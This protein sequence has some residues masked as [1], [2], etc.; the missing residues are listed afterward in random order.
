MIEAG[1]HDRGGCRARQPTGRIP[2]AV[3]GARQ[4][5]SRRPGAGRDQTRGWGRTRSGRLDASSDVDECGSRDLAPP[6][7]PALTA[8]DSMPSLKGVKVAIL[9]DDGFEQVELTG[10]R[11]AL[12]V[13]MAECQVVSPKPDQVRAW[14]FTDWGDKFPV[15]VPL[16][17]ANPN[18]FDALLLPGGV[19]NPDSLRMQPPAV[20]FVKAWTVIEAGAA[21]GRRIASWPS[22]K[23][24]LRNA[25]AEWIDAEVVVDGNLVSEDE[26]EGTVADHRH[27]LARG[28]ST[29]SLKAGRSSGLRLVYFAYEYHW[30]GLDLPS[31][32]PDGR[33]AAVLF[34][35]GY[36]AEKAIHPALVT[37]A[38]RTVTT[39]ALR[40]NTPRS[41][42]SRNR[43]KVTKAI[44]TNM[45]ACGAHGQSIE[46]VRGRRVLRDM[47][48]LHVRCRRLR[49]VGR[50]ASAPA[51]RGSP[52][53]GCHSA[54]TTSSSSR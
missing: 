47:L 14:S 26:G 51:R 8:E 44:H 16:A 34:L 38:S 39:R 36:V 40:W 11:K 27:R 20:Q 45:V 31:G 17:R 52:S 35:T 42:A 19:M 23:T 28:E 33:T 10:P 46:R 2:P 53:R 12:D 18:D 7:Q 43:T 15:D 32:E 4:N 29:P 41:S 21:R 48:A 37:S 22:L 49:P 54:W 13:A 6:L 30:F 5:V 1:G 25:G 24:D 3:N 50:P 9:V